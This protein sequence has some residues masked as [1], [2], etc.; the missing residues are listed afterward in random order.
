ML[1]NGP[2]NAVMHRT[3][4]LKRTA[5]KR[6]IISSRG[7]YMSGDTTKTTRSY[8]PTLYIEALAAIFTAYSRTPNG[9]PMSP[10]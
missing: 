1:E 10:S 4:D 6:S 7:I 3:R 5:S 9:Y 2:G 8:L